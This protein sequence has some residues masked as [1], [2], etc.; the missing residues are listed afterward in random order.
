MD[1]EE[2]KIFTFE[3]LQETPEEEL[4]KVIPEYDIV[5]LECIDLSNIKK[6][7]FKD[8]AKVNIA[9]SDPL[10]QQIDFTNCSEVI[11]SGRDTSKISPQK[12]KDGSSFYYI[13]RNFDTGFYINKLP[14]LFPN[15]DI[16]RCQNI[17]IQNTD[18]QNV[19]DLKFKKGSNVSLSGCTNFPENLDLSV[20]DSVDLSGCD[21]SNLKNLKFKKGAAV[22]LTGCTN[23]PENIDL[24]NHNAVTLSG[25]ANIPENLDFSNCD[26]VNLSGCDLSNI[27]NLKFKKGARVNLSGCTNIPEDLDISQCSSVDFSG[28]QKLPENL[29]FSNCDTVN[30]SKA[31][32][33]QVKNLQF[34]QDS[35][36]NLSETNLPIGKKTD[37]SKCAEV[38]LKKTDL[39]WISHLKFKDNSSVNLS[40]AYLPNSGLDVSN[41]A[42]VNLKKTDLTWITQLK[43]KDGAIVNLEEAYPLPKDLD[44]SNCDTVNL[45]RTDLIN[46]KNIKFKDG[47][48]ISLVATENIPAPLDVS[49]CSYVWIR[50]TQTSEIN[51]GDAKVSLSGI[52]SREIDVSNLNNFTLPPSKSHDVLG[53]EHTSLLSLQTITFK[54]Q[55]QYE[56]YIK[57]EDNAS[58]P[59]S[60]KIIYADE[61]NNLK[62]QLLNQ[63]GELP[64][65]IGNNDEHFNRHLNERTSSSKTDS[66]EKTTVQQLSAAT[67]SQLKQ[68]TR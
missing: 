64:H 56:E 36:V 46:N 43:F 65:Q 2:T 20:C 62:Q 67:L 28:C 33:Q 17:T 38:N 31:N 25:C 63:T 39:T 34:K 7:H 44:V 37:V 51:A 15:L 61:K 50:A 22:N 16:S 42:Q 53:Q 8:N 30:L 4:P 18:L 23:I 6:L 27:K 10:P 12:L 45:G 59:E 54:N 40:E 66:D 49:N 26:A 35:S 57:N 32:A 19:P 60:C 9:G 29:D 21:L 14:P 52:G 58:I 47:A 5:D 24:S 55:Q 13:P 41:C 3:T 48:E 1:D 11:I 68:T